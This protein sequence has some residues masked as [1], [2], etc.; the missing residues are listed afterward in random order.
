MIEPVDPDHHVAAPGLP[1]ALDAAD[2][3]QV[4]PAGG[5]EHSTVPD[6]DHLSA[7]YNGLIKELLS[8]SLHTA[9]LS[10]F[11]KPL[12]ELS[13]WKE[14]RNFGPVLHTGKP[15][16]FCKLLSCREVD[17]LS[18]LGSPRFPLSS[19]GLRFGGT[20][21]LP[22]ALPSGWFGGFSGNRSG[23]SWRG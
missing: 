6:A 10:G 21:P 18:P 7:A 11:P 23:R 22:R 15:L 9:S 3:R 19:I 4:G 12:P 8:F 20:A 2:K 5:Q 16:T 13:G 17:P 1:H 14:S